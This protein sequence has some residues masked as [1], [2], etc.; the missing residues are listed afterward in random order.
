MSM[1]QGEAV[2]QAVIA[3][4]GEVKGKVELTTEQKKEVHELVFM[5]FNTNQTAHKSNPNEEQLRK[6]IPGLVNNWVRKDKRLNGGTKYAA[7]NPG[8]RAGSGDDALKAM[9]QLLA[10]T[11]DEGAREEIQEAITIRMKALKP[12]PVVNIE[13]LPPT[14]R[15]FVQE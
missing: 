8:S 13:A 11:T 5:D 4:I 1:S 6:Y 7:K 12:K 14:L 9:K 15:R 3:V 2:Y 10:V